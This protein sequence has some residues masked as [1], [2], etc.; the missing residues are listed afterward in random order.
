[1]DSRSEIG[2]LSDPATGTVGASGGGEPALDLEDLLA[3]AKP[4]A[5]HA[6]AACK[7]HP[8]VTWFPGRGEHPGPAIAI[9]RGC[10]VVG[11]CLRWAIEAGPRLHGIWGGMT[12]TQRRQFRAAEVARRRMGESVTA[13]RPVSA[14][15]S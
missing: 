13:T 14:A 10:L 2:R 12:E 3:L 11:E 5:W 4:P 15:G 1:M 9:C 7:E 6:D 8:E